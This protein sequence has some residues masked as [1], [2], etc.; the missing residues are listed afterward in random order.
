VNQRLFLKFSP[1]ISV[2]QLTE[3]DNRRSDTWH[4]KQ[5]SNKIESEEEIDESE[6]SQKFRNGNRIGR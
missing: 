4:E 1:Q 2:E 3:R 6:D 5:E